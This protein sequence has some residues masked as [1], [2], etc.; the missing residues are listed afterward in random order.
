MIFPG[1]VVITKGGQMSLRPSETDLLER[2]GINSLQMDDLN[3]SIPSG[4]Y[5]FLNFIHH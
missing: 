5:Y 3:C 4:P 2:M 1:H